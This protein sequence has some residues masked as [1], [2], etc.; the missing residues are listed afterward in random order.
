MSE[1]IL[2]ENFNADLLEK[3]L[4]NS[5]GDKSV[6]VLNFK[7]KPAV[8]NG[9]NYT[10]DV[11]RVLVDYQIKN[12]KPEQMSLIV[13]YILDAESIKDLLTEYKLYI[14]E[15]E[16]YSSILPKLSE[17]LN[18]N[19][20]PKCLYILDDSSKIFVME[21]LNDLGYVVADRQAGL[22]L[23]SCLLV[24]KKLAKFHAGSMV[25]AESQPEIMEEFDFGMIK[26]NAASGNAVPSLLLD[27]LK[28]LIEVAADWPDFEK[29]VEK[30]I[31]IQDNIEER[32][33]KCVDQEC[34]FKVL[35]HGD[36]WTN[37]FMIKYDSS[38]KTPVDVI[39]VN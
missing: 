22:D 13:K 27:G 29:I 24:V 10:S 14:K 12:S 21:D 39:F 9:D 33:L 23:E 37:N 19:C 7:T 17:M 11:Y 25:L 34:S 15:K 31:K 18:E 36:M 30:L 32:A 3:A 20:G 38:K 5:F 26:R 6:K 2:P 28:T 8:A 4:I 16:M 35:N 1:L